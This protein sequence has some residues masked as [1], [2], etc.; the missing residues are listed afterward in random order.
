MTLQEQL[1]QAADAGHRE[2]IADDFAAAAARLASEQQRLAAETEA[3]ANLLKA[4]PSRMRHAARSGKAV[5]SAH[6]VQVS[7][8]NLAGAMNDRSPLQATSLTGV[9]RR[10]F[11]ELQEMKLNPQL[12]CVG[13]NEHQIAVPVLPATA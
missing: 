4:L 2:K 8:I 10:F 13:P 9:S 3:S 7:D 12:T 6:I 5:C 1:Q 11:D